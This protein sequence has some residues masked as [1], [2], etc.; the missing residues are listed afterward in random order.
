MEP[1]NRPDRPVFPVRDRFDRFF[2]GS[3]ADRFS[4]LTRPDTSLVHGLTDLTSRFGP[5]LTTLLTRTKMMFKDILYYQI[6]NVG[7]NGR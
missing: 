4:S 5:I 3:P 6:K 1:S 7:L 2:T